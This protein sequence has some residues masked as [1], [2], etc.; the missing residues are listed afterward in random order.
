MHITKK[1]EIC[2]DCTAC[3]IYDKNPDIESSNTRNPKRIC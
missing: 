3:D 1:I 2:D